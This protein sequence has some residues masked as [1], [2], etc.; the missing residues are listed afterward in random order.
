M[1]VALECSTLSTLMD[2]AAFEKLGQTDWH[3]QSAGVLSICIL[4]V[5]WMGVQKSSVE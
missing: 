2:A 1:V 3:Q 4:V 5:A